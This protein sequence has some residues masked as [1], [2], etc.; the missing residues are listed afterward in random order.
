MEINQ[1][2]QELLFQSTPPIREATDFA[3]ISDKYKAI[4]IHAPHT[5][6]D[7]K[8]MGM[9]ATLSISIHAPHTGGDP[10]SKGLATD[11]NISIHAPHTGGD[12]KHPHRQQQNVIFQ[13]T[14]PIREATRS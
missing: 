1:R 9:A 5:G 3:I 6:G 14:P 10:G 7:G 2:L 4:S 8:R 13:S 11:P 12:A